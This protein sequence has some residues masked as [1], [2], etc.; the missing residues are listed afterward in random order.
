M[1]VGPTGAESTAEEVRSYGR[2]AV[3]KQL[4]FDGGMLQMGP[5]AGSHL[6]SNDWRKA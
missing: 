2:N 5:R 4:D 1:D 6:S 3:V